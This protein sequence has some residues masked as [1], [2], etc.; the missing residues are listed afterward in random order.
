[1]LEREFRKPLFPDMTCLNEALLWANWYVYSRPQQDKELLLWESTQCKPGFSGAADVNSQWRVLTGRIKSVVYSLPRI[2][3]STIWVYYANFE[4]IIPYKNFLFSF[5]FF[6]AEQAVRGEGA[7]NATFQGSYR[8]FRCETPSS[9]Q[10]T[11]VFWSPT[12]TI[13]VLLKP[14]PKVA[15]TDSWWTTIPETQ[16]Q[17][18]NQ[19]GSSKEL[20]TNHQLNSGNTWAIV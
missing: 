17:R 14:L 2:C 5:W 20:R 16:R 3:T 19:L 11:L 18:N 13:H 8:V 7:E 1:M 12:S 10:H 6:I 9:T 15:Q 4:Y